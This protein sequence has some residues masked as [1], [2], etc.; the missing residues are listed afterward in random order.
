[1]TSDFVGR[2]VV[3]GAQ[4][5]YALVKDLSQGTANG[6]VPMVSG[7]PAEEWPVGQAAD[8]F[9]LIR[10]RLLGGGWRGGGVPGNGESNAAAQHD[11]IVSEN[12]PFQDV[13]TRRQRGRRYRQCFQVAVLR[14]ME[15][16]L[17]VVVLFDIHLVQRYRLAEF[18]DEGRWRRIA[19]TAV[20]RRRLQK[21]CVRGMS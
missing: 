6:S 14:T 5:F 17:P 9:R 20:F 15:R 3:I 2:F 8:T 19:D 21:F 7:M 12:A 13:V 11:G 18:E 1:V 4:V 10:D 16:L